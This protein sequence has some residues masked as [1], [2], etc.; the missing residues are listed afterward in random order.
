MN[1]IANGPNNTIYLNCS[2]TLVTGKIIT[3]MS[4]KSQYTIF[5]NT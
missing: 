5:L 4:T 3:D 1:N 2:D